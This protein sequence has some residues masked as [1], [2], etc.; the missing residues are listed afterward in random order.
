VLQL[1]PLA[2]RFELQRHVY[3]YVFF[4]NFVDLLL[5]FKVGQA[6]CKLLLFKEAEQFTLKPSLNL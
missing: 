1:N 2:T 4:I 3:Q 5:S 6:A